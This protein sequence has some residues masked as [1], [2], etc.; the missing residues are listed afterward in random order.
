MSK[1]QIVTLMTVM[2]L[3]GRMRTFLMMKMLQGISEA[4]GLRACI[5]RVAPPNSLRPETKT[6]ARHTAPPRPEP[7]MLY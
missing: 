1:Y 6:H 2:T 7:A 5:P 3:M 4:T